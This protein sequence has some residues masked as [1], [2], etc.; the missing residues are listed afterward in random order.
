LVANAL[1]N[2][3]E[4]YNWSEKAK[5]VLQLCVEKLVRKDILDAA[6]VTNNSTIESRDITLVQSIHT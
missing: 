5:Q 2:T 1:N 6:T 4:T 3:G